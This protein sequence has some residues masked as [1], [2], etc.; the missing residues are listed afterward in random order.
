MVIVVVNYIRAE[1]KKMLDELD[2]MDPVTKAKALSKLEKIT[3]NIA[4]PKEI[5]DDKMINEFYSGLEIKNDSYLLNSLRQ[6]KFRML[7]NAEEFR[8]KIDKKDWKTH[9]RAAIVNAFYYDFKN[10]KEIL[11]G[12]L[13]GAF[14]EVESTYYYVYKIT[15]IFSTLDLNT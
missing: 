3:P 7:K 9:G 5:L 15:Y 8:K 14:F 11:A 1:F 4:Y 13:G 6:K 12:I 2:W 10:S